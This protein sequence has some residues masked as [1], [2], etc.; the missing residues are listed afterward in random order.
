[1]EMR[2]KI[3]NQLN[4]YI[5]TVFADVPKTA[6]MVALINRVKTKAK[7]KYYTIVDQGFEPKVAA[8]EVK[9]WLKDF[10]SVLDQAGKFNADG[11]VVNPNATSIMVEMLRSDDKL[12][13]EAPTEP[14][15]ETEDYFVEEPVEEVYYE[16]TPADEYV[17]EVPETEYVEEAPTDEHVEAEP[18]PEPQVVIKEGEKVEKPKKAK[19]GGKGGRI[20]LAIGLFA[21]AAVACYFLVKNLLPLLG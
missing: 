12:D 8:G 16:E 10:K 19:K 3:D 6:N 20:A 7:N 4:T 21:A 5:D 17:E 15:V 13:A 1:M 9:N 18:I 11:S 14:T 2:A